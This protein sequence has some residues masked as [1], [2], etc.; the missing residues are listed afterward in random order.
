MTPNKSLV[1]LFCAETLLESDP[2]GML[3]SALNGFKKLPNSD[4][5]IPLPVDGIA[6]ATWLANEYLLEVSK[7]LAK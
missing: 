1:E 4:C 5:D 3:D 7:I 2:I 6:T